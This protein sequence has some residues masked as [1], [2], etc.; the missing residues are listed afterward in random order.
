MAREKELGSI[1]NFYATPVTR[2]EFLLGKQLPYIGLAMVNYFSMLA[3]AVFL[4]QV[5]VKGSLLALTLGAFV[6]S[7][8]TTGL[9]LLISGFAAT[10]V[11]AMAA[12]AVLTIMPATQFSGLIVPVSS[13]STAAM[14]VG[15]GFPTTYFVKISVGAFTKALGFAD[16][17]GNLLNLAAF[18][19]V[20]T[21]LSL[22]FIPKQDR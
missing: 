22:C 21:G 5:P 20:L 8:T 9:G 18:V 13:L 12:T 6:Y 10:Q 1:V 11:A 16:L 17:A 19:P 4:F 15:Y 2:L 7:I 3:L 14:V